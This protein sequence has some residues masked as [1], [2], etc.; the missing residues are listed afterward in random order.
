[1]EVSQAATARDVNRFMNY[2][3]RDSGLVIVFNGEMVTGWEAAAEAQRVY[4]AQLFRAAYNV[5]KTEVTVL[6]PDIAIATN[7]GTALEVP[8]IG[9]HRSGRF[10][11]TMV[12][13]RRPQG[14]R[15]IQVH[16]STSP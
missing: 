16:E 7:T 4:W 9:E 12:W 5:E 10:V 13:H 3:Q 15:I 6:S 1:L 8:R 11:S 2:L 14:W